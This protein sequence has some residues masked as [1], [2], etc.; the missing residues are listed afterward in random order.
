MKMQCSCNNFIYSNY[1]AVHNTYFHLH[2][3]SDSLYMGFMEFPNL[4]IWKCISYLYKKLVL[5][6]L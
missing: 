3:M 2:Q 6:F 4:K 5:K 1:M